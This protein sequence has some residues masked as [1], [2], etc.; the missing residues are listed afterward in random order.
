MSVPRIDTLRNQTAGTIAYLV[1]ARSLLDLLHELAYTRPR[2][3]EL[4][5]VSG[6]DQ[7]Y[8]LDTHGDPTARAAYKTFG[9]ELLRGVDVIHKALVDVESILQHGPSAD[10]SR[11]NKIRITVR[12]HVEALDAQR[13]RIA[14]GEFTPAPKVPQ[15]IRGGT[16][17]ALTRELAKVERER[18]SLRRKVQRLENQLARAREARRR[19]VL[20]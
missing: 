3:A 7:S 11:G 5:R 9:P 10:T 16:E 8:Y 2:G 13:R 20:G 14:R 17:Q 15:P 6:G 1:R 19:A 18:D 4:E 12:E